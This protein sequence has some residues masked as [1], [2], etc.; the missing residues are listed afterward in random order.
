M[1][2]ISSLLLILGMILITQSC[3]F[4]DIK[5]RE[6][7]FKPEM[8]AVADKYRNMLEPE[9]IQTGPA[10]FHIDTIATHKVVVTIFNA[11]KLPDEGPELLKLAKDI[12]ADTYDQIINTEDF[13]L[14]EVI[15]QRSSGDLVKV[16]TQRNFVFSFEELDE[17]PEEHETIA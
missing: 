5:L 15:F 4:P 13:N 8:Q 6:I 11:E 9:F 12:A 10:W 14:I 7:K 17:P 16:Q 2:K 1:R 3:S